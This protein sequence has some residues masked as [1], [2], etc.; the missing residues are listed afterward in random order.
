MGKKEC[1]IKIVGEWLEEQE[2]GGHTPSRLSQ[3]LYAQCTNIQTQTHIFW[4]GKKK[5]PSATAEYNRKQNFISL[6]P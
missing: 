2:V 4:R 3:F 5:S 6:S 1:A